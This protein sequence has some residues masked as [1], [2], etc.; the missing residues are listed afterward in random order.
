MTDEKILHFPARAN[1]LQDMETHLRRSA[2]LARAM[3]LFVDSAAFVDERDHTAAMALADDVADHASAAL[4]LF[5]E[6]SNK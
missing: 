1:F 5:Y 6:K 2:S 3:S 4:H